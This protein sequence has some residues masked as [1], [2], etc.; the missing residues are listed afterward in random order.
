MAPTVFG[1]SEIQWLYFWKRYHIPKL[2]CCLVSKN[3]NNILTIWLTF[4]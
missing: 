1:T 3:K 2:D 4:S